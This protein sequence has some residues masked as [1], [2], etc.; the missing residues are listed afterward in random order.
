MAEMGDCS[1]EFKDD[2]ELLLAEAGWGHQQAIVL[3]PSI[4]DKG[5]EDIS[6]IIF[7]LT[8]RSWGAGGGCRSFPSQQYL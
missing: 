8:G 1:Q 5:Y 4:N 3:S 2:A 7:P 6:K